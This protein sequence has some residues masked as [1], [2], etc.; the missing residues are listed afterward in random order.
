MEEPEDKV[1]VARN[2]EAE[3][4]KIVP[5][6][7]SL[8]LGKVEADDWRSIS[9]EGECSGQDGRGKTDVGTASIS[10]Q[11]GWSPSER[12]KRQMWKRLEIEP[13]PVVGIITHI[14]NW[15]CASTVGVTDQQF[16]ML[17]AET[18][19]NNSVEITV[20]FIAREIDDW[21]KHLPSGFYPITKWN[22]CI[23]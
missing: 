16:E 6:S 15:S 12:D 9:L 7:R 23:S 22:V 10:F 3:H 4:F 17:V 19:G 20:E 2:P 18:R 13:V 14:D 5:D 1:S 21:G 11:L 8:E